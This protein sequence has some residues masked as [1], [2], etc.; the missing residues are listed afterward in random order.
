MD[1]GKERLERHILRNYDDLRNDLDKDGTSR[2]SPYL[3]FGVFSVRQIYTT[4]QHISETYLSEMAWRE[5]W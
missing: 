4:A 2:L 1:F 5:F 3:R